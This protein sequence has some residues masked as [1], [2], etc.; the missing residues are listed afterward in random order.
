VLVH[1]MKPMLKAPAIDCLKLN[2]DKLLSSFG[3][4]LDLRPYTEVYFPLLAVVLPKWLKAQAE[5]GR[6][7]LVHPM[8][9]VLRVA[10][11]KILKLKYDGLLSNVAF[12]IQLA[13]LHRGGR[14]G[15]QPQGSGGG[16]GGGD[17]GGG[18]RGGSG[19]GGDGSG[20]GGGASQ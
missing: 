16:D 15:R 5:V 20:D 6:C 18:D 14:G 7:R 10:E 19:G 12:K 11:T 9:P 1:P 13:P 3:F 2:Y 4:N 17:G 8:K